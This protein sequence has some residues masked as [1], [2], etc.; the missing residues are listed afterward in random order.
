MERI[1]VLYEDVRRVK[2]MEGS[3]LSKRRRRQKMYG[4]MVRERNFCFNILNVKPY[5]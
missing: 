5:E 3:V 2:K 4:V 1:K